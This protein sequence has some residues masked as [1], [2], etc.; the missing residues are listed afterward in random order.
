MHHFWRN[1]AE[2]E[3]IHTACRHRGFAYLR[4][5]GLRTHD[6]PPARQ[7]HCVSLH[8]ASESWFA[9]CWF[10][11]VV[12]SVFLRTSRPILV[13]A[14]ALLRVRLNTARLL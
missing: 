14:T 10:R 11:A 8:H 6:L 5:G 4:R 1:Q 12:I 13:N 7:V 2:L 9:V 3:L